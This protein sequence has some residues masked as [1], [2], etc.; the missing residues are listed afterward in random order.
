MKKYF[1]AFIVLLIMGL[2]VGTDTAGAH[3]TRFHSQ[4]RHLDVPPVD[5][6]DRFGRIIRRPSGIG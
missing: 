5:I 1:S 6:T 4:D 2:G 3:G